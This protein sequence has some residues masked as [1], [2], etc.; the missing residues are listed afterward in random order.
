MKG[1]LFVFLFGYCLYPFS[2]LVPRSCHKWAFGS[3]RNAFTDNAKYLFI[4]LSEHRKDLDL[5]WLSASRQTVRHIRQL[6]LK[7]EF[8]G[9]PRGVW[10]ALRAKY[11]F[12]NAYTSD[13]L[14]FAS[15]R[16]ICTNLWHGVGLKKIEFSIQD[17]PLA[18]RYVK[19]TLKEQFFHPEAFR[20]PNYLLSSTP[21]QSVKFAEAFRINL[22]Q[23]INAGYPRNWILTAEE[24]ERTLFITH[25]EMP[26]S[27]NTIQ[28]LAA[29]DTVY[30]YMPT[31][32]DSQKD[33]FSDIMNLRVLNDVLKEKNSLLILKPHA[34]TVVDTEKLS[35]FSHVMLLDKRM[36]IYPLL[37]YTDVLITDYSSILY[38]YLLMENKAVILYLY[39]FE[40]YVN[41]RDFNYPYYENVAGTAVYS[42]NELVACIKSG[43]H[44]IDE[45]K[46]QALLKKFWGEPQNQEVYERIITA[47]TTK[48]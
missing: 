2:F 41:T 4:Y 12:F 33:V 47:T 36:D 48:N 26:A 30:I 20:R 37:P 16:A 43:N 27:L 8:I 45:Q 34:N 46:R 1:K 42:F 32:R 9:S 23:C 24:K 21:F 14:F 29:F 40:E 3:F 17:G 18:D 35:K 39:D 44:A 19:K 28:Q 11:W 6:G 25:Y 7:A 5:V 10:F 15:G 22:S 38:D 13:I 31:W